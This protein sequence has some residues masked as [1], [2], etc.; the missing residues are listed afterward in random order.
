MLIRCHKSKVERLQSQNPWIGVQKNIPAKEPK[1]CAK[2]GSGD[3]LVFYTDGLVEV[4]G[5]NRWQPGINGLAD[6]ALKAMKMDLF[7]MADCILDKVTHNRK[8][9]PKDDIS[10]IVVEIK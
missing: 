1:Q 5:T 10:L 7:E 9:S 3:R 6:I 2:L 8:V 4:V